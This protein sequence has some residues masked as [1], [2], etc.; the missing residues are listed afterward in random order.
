MELSRDALTVFAEEFVARLPAARGARAHVVGLSGELG[1][2][3]TTFVQEIGKAL[4]VR[5]SI[6]SPTFTILQSYPIT[7][8]V[9]THLI[10][11][12]AY[13]LSPDEPDTIQWRAYQ[14]N[15][16]NLIIVEWPENLH[17]FPNNAPVLSFIVT[18]QDTRDIR[19]AA[20][21]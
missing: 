3:K 12:D 15:P 6:T 21:N 1:S 13:R 7:H 5:H 4:H 20:Q 16:A 8:P 9:F 18:G 2:G 17:G 11:V 19:H 14:E 10:H